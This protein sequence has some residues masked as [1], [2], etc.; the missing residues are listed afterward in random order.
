MAA[1][2]PL[3]C[4]QWKSKR[5]FTYAKSKSDTPM[6]QT[7]QPKED[8]IITTGKIMGLDLVSAIGGKVQGS[9]NKTVVHIDEDASFSM[10][11]TSMKLQSVTALQFGIGVK[12]M[13]LNNKSRA[14]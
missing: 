2:A 6:N 10:I 8:L 14:W 12:V 7:V 11:A 13:V 4:K 9:P 1:F 3:I 5:P